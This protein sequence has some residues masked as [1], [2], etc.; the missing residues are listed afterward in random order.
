MKKWTSLLL[1]AILVIAL[2]VP[3]SAAEPGMNNFQE[4]KYTY[5]GFTDVAADAWYATAVKSCYESGLMQGT[6][7]TTFNPKGNLTVAQAIVMAARLRSVYMGGTGTFEKSTPW[8]ESALTYAMNNGI[9]TKTEFTWF[10]DF[11]QPVT[12]GGMAYLFNNALTYDSINT[13][14]KLPDVQENDNHF[15]PAIFNL[16][17]AG[18]LTGNDVYGTFAPNDTITRQAACAII[19]RAAFPAQRQTLSLY[20]EFTYG[21]IS[22]PMPSGSTASTSSSVYEVSSA[23]NLQMSVVSKDVNTSYQG[24]SI[25]VMDAASV[26]KLL[27]DA[28]SAN[29]GVTISDAS[30]QPVSFGKTA[31]YRMTFTATSSGV[32]IPAGSYVYISGDTLYIYAC[33]TAGGD[34]SRKTMMNAV[35]VDGNTVSSKL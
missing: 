15:G 16:Y 18:V 9:I 11:N 22:F 28:L 24:M 21:D 4:K 35:I 23:N 5:N 6:T 25:T 27:V 17:R 32:Q 10:G 26:Q 2:V 30:T 29:S 8:Y 34:T 33:I 31:A 13:V 1:A 12:R 14:T 7:A 3:A 19:A 20:E